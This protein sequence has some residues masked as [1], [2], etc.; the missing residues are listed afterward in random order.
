MLADGVKKLEFKQDTKL[1]HAGTFTIMHE[2]H[3]L[4]NMVRM[5]LH[6]DRQIVFAGYRIPHPLTAKMVIKVQTNGSKSPEA[7][8]I[9]ALDDLTTEVTTIQKKLESEMARIKS[10]QAPY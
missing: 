2:D 5:Q 4:G 7:A 1:E 3:T 9:H 8:L 10:S 6:L